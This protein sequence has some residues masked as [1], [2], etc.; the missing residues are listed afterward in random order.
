MNYMTDHLLEAIK[1]NRERSKL[2]RD[3]SDGESLF[4]SRFLIFSE[5][6]TLP[7]SIVLDQIAKIWRKRN[8]PVFKYEF[9]SMSEIPEFSK[10]YS[11]S[12][13]VTGNEGKKINFTLI[14]N[15]LKSAFSSKDFDLI[16]EAFRE[17]IKDLSQ[18][19]RYYCMFRHLLESGLRGSNLAPKHI[20][21]A[22]E[23]G[24]ISPYY[25]C[26][27]LAFNHIYTLW[28]AEYLDRKALRIQKKGIPII[29]QDVPHIPEYPKHLEA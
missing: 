8:I 6:I 23:K 1:I 7:M 3:L 9:I 10:S 19:P 28:L 29:F 12:E 21:G 22:K 13:S 27:F 2:Y 11:G 25:F 5:L 24:V 17:G 20:E 18:S 4:V 16:S 26:R 14:K 15:R